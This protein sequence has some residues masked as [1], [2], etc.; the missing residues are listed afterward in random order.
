M[1]AVRKSVFFL[2]LLA[3]AIC[4]VFLLAE[5][6]AKENLSVLCSGR[7]TLSY[8]AVGVGTGQLAA[9]AGWDQDQLRLEVFGLDGTPAESWSVEL[10]GQAGGAIA[11]L[12][13]CREDLVL[14]G[15]YSPGAETLS[16]YRLIRGQDAEVFMQESCRGT[17][18]ADRRSGTRL[19][20][21][22]QDGGKVSFALL[23][24]DTVT[25]YT[26]PLETGG[27]TQ[28]GSA[29]LGNAS[30]AAALPDGTLVL[31]GTGS[32]VAGGQANPNVAADQQVT[33]LTRR[34]IHLYYLDGAD[35]SV[36]YS[37]LTN[38]N[39]RR[40]LS[41][42]QAAG[43]SR[44]SSLSLTEEG[45]A[46]LLLD[47][48]TLRLVTE[49]GTRD[50]EGILYPLQSRAAL[51]LALLLG[52]ALVMA[53]VVWYLVCGRSQGWAP[54]ALHGGCLVAALALCSALAVEY[55]VILPR[56]DLELGRQRSRLVDGVAQAA[57][58]QEGLGLENLPGALAGALEEIQD[59][60]FQDL[61]AVFA[62][63]D[64]DGIWR[65]ADGSRAQLSPA[66]DPALAGQA[67]GSE[68]AWARQ[69]TTFRWCLRQGDQAVIQ[70]LD[71]LEGPASGWPLFGGTALVALAAILLLA[72]AGHN[73]RRLT[74][75]AA[76]LTQ[77][78]GRLRLGTGDE[79]AVLAAALTGAAD[80]LD[81]RQ[82]E[83]DALEQSY[84]RFVPEKLLTLLGKQS[85]RQV[86]KSSFASRRMAVMM[87]WFQFPEPL[88]TQAA[89]SRLLFDSVNQ[90]IERTASQASRKGGTVFRFSYD[91][92]DVVME[93]DSRQVIST[94]VAIQQEVLAFNEGRARDGLPCVKFHIALDVGDVLLGVVGDSAQIEPT[95]I[96]TSFSVVR[97]L[98][99]LSDRL[100]ACILC[101]ESIIGGAGDYG[102]RYMGKC[103]LDDSAIRVYEIFDGD[104]YDV[105]KG[106]AQTVEQF[107][108]GVYALY[109]GQTAQAKRTFL[110]LVHDN[111]ADGGARYY[112]YLADRLEQDPGLACGLNPQWNHQRRD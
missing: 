55:G 108:Q 87:I 10:P 33:G 46:L 14:A 84:R 58:Q 35:L 16:V 78:G 51:V 20:V 88:Y 67:G 77:N 94:A 45:G 104:E 60:G 63:L 23:S 8:E 7:G 19:S 85:I 59:S 21:F 90:L 75:A 48:C 47:G 1:S 29:A 36:Y 70:S 81:A 107:S 49:E 76:A 57:L 99:R 86:D 95:T 15:V 3:L 43:D 110:E 30:C 56:Q 40:V 50:L 37:D 41:L 4:C 26:V 89:N 24:G 11:A 105:R 28:T 42:D 73:V 22:S 52:I 71:V 92:Y 69:G 98:V 96:S 102:S 2:S 9:A 13:P 64:G 25:S 80:T 100:D 39:V 53:L 18:S 66:F 111:P 38:N 109:S 82:R 6:T 83:R 106:K 12:Y 79:L 44:I 103:W 27:L 91:G 61:E 97:E 68:V 31:G 34:G 112:L 74:R 5:D 54:M 101:T 62:R 17:S 72:A 65:L 93:N 32:L